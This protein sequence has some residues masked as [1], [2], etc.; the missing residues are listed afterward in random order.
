MIPKIIWQTY[1]E[2]N[3]KDLPDFAKRCMMTWFA[4][5]P[6]YTHV[7][8][9]DEECSDFILK[10]FG[11]KI[12]NIYLAFPL[13]VMKADFWR[14]CILYVY[15]GVYADIDTLCKI[16]LDIWIDEKYNFICGLEDLTAINNWTFASSPR[17]PI[18]KHVIN[19]IIEKNI[20]PDFSSTHFVHALTGPSI[21]T[22]S[23]LDYF[24]IENECNLLTHDFQKYDSFLCFNRNF[25]TF[26]RDG[27]V[28]HLFGSVLWPDTYKS[29]TKERELLLLSLSQFRQDIDVL[30]FFNF[31]N[32]GYFVDV[33][34]YDGKE[35]SN[36][37]VLEHFY[38]W[39]G[40]CFEPLPN[41]FKMCQENRPNSICINKAAFSESGKEFNFAVYK[42]LS[43]ITEYIDTH[44]NIFDF[45]EFIKVQSVTLTEI[46]NE[47]NAPLYIEYLSIDTEGSELEVLKGIDFEKYSFGIIHIEHNFEELKR[48]NIK[49]FL[50]ERGYFFQKENEVDD[51]YILLK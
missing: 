36:T 23:I 51:Y 21:F 2:K 32:N 47:N 40:I 48:K 42:G 37:Y 33:G 34:A 16:P 8:M 14:Y 10:H 45:C 11:E 28:V 24:Q 27:A 12:H 20:N 15:G 17:N 44:K 29:W 6:N 1:K 30:K 31:K 46:L 43:G 38:H 5:N 18:L 50:E 25:S 9:N 7:Y 22:E 26:L 35:I 49:I 19:K 3:P 39:K 4:L 13:A 41:E